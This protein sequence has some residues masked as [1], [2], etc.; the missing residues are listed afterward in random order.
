MYL[1]KHPEDVLNM[2]NVIV[3]CKIRLCGLF[4]YLQYYLDNK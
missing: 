1:Q 4:E 2:L 3:F